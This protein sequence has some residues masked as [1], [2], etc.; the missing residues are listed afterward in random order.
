MTP[1]MLLLAVAGIG[2]AALCAQALVQPSA[3]I[4][5]NPSASVARG[6]YRIAP[7]AGPGSLHVGSIV[8]VRL[9]ASVAAFAAQRDYLPAGVP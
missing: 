7:L 5:Y 1:R 6:W 2:L 9:P 8:L 4:V 3:R